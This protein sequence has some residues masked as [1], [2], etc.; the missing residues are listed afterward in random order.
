MGCGKSS[1]GR[2]LAALT[3]HRFVDTDDLIVQSEGYGIPEIF[4]RHGE[5][6]FREVEQRSI[7]ELEGICGIVLSTGGGLVLRPANREILK[8]IGVVAWLDAEPD[9]LFE[10][11]S[12]SGRRPL[13]QT[14]N[15]RETFDRLLESR[16][17]IYAEVADFRFD[18][19]HCGHDE[20]AQLLLDQAMRHRHRF[21]G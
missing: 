1:V 15:P 17:D 11:A 7:S 12:R 13:L 5:D 3:G 4:A 8:R 20:A 21:E 2:R 19:T 14:E 18:S 10:R 6:Y 9:L 16:R